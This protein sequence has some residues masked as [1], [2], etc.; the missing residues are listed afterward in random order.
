MI[1]EFQNRVI[2]ETKRLILRKIH[3]KDFERFNLMQSDIKVMQFTT[4][5]ALTLEENQRQFYNLIDGYEHEDPELLVWAIETKEDPFI[6]TAALVKLNQEQWEIG[7]R[8]L[9]EYWGNGF[10]HEICEGLIRLC[11]AIPTIKEIVAFADIR[12]IASNKILL[13]SGFTQIKKELN[14]ELNC[15][16]YHYKIDVT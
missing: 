2:L 7:F 16:D 14:T 13:K 15:E 5:R 3:E 12:N 8:F 6:G 11:E 10:G 9:P 1:K 4:M